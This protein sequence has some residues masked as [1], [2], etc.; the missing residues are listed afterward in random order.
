MSEVDMRAGWVCLQPWSCISLPRALVHDSDERCD[1]QQGSWSQVSENPD[2]VCETLPRP[3]VKT[4]SPRNI[5]NIPPDAPSPEALWEW[6]FVSVV[7]DLSSWQ[8]R[9]RDEPDSSKRLSSQQGFPVSPRYS[10]RWMRAPCV[11][12]TCLTHVWPFAVSQRMNILK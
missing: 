10:C 4:Q 8:L 3:P 11:A 7:T 12:S 2:N 9:K 6:R 1:K 5:F